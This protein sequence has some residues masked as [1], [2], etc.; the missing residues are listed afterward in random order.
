MEICLVV[1]VKREELQFLRFALSFVPF[2]G[3]STRLE[4]SLK[5]AFSFWRGERGHFGEIG[6]TVLVSMRCRTEAKFK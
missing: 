5:M 4:R 3:K 1:L 6:C 2:L